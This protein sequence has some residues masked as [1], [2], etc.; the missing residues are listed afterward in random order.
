MIIWKLSGLFL[1]ADGLEEA[2]AVCD[3]VVELLY[4]ASGT[5]G[6]TMAFVVD[7]KYTEPRCGQLDPTR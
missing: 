3:E 4:V 7:A 6:L 2:V 5:H 1:T